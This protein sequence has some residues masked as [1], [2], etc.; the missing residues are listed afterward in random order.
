MLHQQPE[1]SV[2]A[3]QADQGRIMVGWREWVSLPELG[4]MLKAK[5]DSGARTSTL[6]A[7]ELEEYKADGRDMV[8]FSIHPIQNNTDQVC[9]CEAELVDMRMVSD[10]GGHRELRPVI[11]TEMELAGQRW[12]I[13]L[14]LTARD[15]MKFRMLLGR[16]AMQGRITIDP[17]VSFLQGRPARKRAR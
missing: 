7:F 16:T 13:E 1:S 9:V 15:N 3:S 2:T 12:P 6:H 4:L 14:T 17:E 10:S 5:V 8:R 11:R